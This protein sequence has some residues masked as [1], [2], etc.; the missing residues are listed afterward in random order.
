MGKPIIGS[1]Y[2]DTL[3]KNAQKNTDKKVKQQQQKKQNTGK[4]TQKRNTN[5]S[6]VVNRNNRSSGTTRGRSGATTPGPVKRNGS[7]RQNKTKK[8]QQKQLAAN[9]AAAAKKKN[10]NNS[11]SSAAPAPLANKS[12]YQNSNKTKGNQPQINQRAHEGIISKTGAVLPKS[13][14]QPSTKKNRSSGGFSSKTGTENI[15]KQAGIQVQNKRDALKQAY[16]T[17]DGKVR[18][19]LGV[20]GAWGDT[21]NSKSDK[22]ML[23]AI[24]IA[25][26]NELNSSIRK[27]MKQQY[28]D[29]YNWDTYEPVT[30]D[31]HTGDYT[32]NYTGTAS[33]NADGTWTYSGGKKLSQI[34]Q[35]GASNPRK[36]Q[37]DKDIAKGLTGKA[38]MGAEEVSKAANQ[39]AWL[40]Q[41]DYGTV[42]KAAEG[43]DKYN[44]T[45]QLKQA[46]EKQ[47]GKNWDEE[48]KLGK[49]L[50]GAKAAASEGLYKVNQGIMQTVDFFAP[51]E[52]LFGED[53]A[54]D[55]WL[56][57]WYGDDSKY[58]QQFQNQYDLAYN[59]SGDAG[60]L[61]MWTTSLLTEN[62]PQAIAAIATAGASAVPSLAADGGNMLLNSLQ[63]VI[64]N[65]SFWTSFAQIAGS[66]YNDAKNSGAGDLTATAHAFTTAF[67]Q[68][69]IEID[70]GLETLNRQETAETLGQLFR[71]TVK[72][73][74]EEGG[75]EVQQD[76]IDHLL[77]MGFYDPNKTLFSTTDDDA[78]INPV[79]AAEN[80]AGGA[81]VGGI[82]GG[83]SQALAYGANARYRNA[84]A[85]AQTNTNVQ[86][87][88]ASAGAAPES[89]AVR[90]AETQQEQTG[91]VQHAQS[92]EQH[93]E[94][95]EVSKRIQDTK[96][97]ADE[98]A[99]SQTAQA[100]GKVIEAA[101]AQMS[102]EKEAVLRSLGN[103]GTEDFVQNDMQQAE[104]S[105]QAA[106]A[107]AYASGMQSSGTAQAK[108]AAVSTAA[109]SIGETRAA[110]AFDAGVQDRAQ[111]EQQ[112]TAAAM[113]QSFD[114]A[115][116]EA[117][118]EYQNTESAQND[119]E[120]YFEAFTRYYNAGLTNTLDRVKSSSW[121]KMISQQ[122]ASAAY[123]AGMQDAS[124]RV[125]IQRDIA[126]G[127]AVS[128]KI[129]T[130]VYESDS[131][132]ISGE[133]QNRLSYYASKL[134][135]RIVVKDSVEGGTK[136]GAI[137][138]DTIYLA[139]DAEGDTLEQALTLTASHEITHRMQT[140]APEKYRTFRDY[141]LRQKAEG[142]ADGM[143]QLISE[144]I[145]QYAQ[146]GI[147]LTRQEAMDEIA[148][149]YAANELMTDPESIQA[150]VNSKPKAARSFWQ[151]LRN[152]FK[153]LRR[154][155]DG[156]SAAE[157]KILR[158]MSTAERLWAD[159]FQAASERANGVQQTSSQ[160]VKTKARK[161]E[162]TK[163]LTEK[164]RKNTRYAVKKELSHAEQQFNI[165]QSSNPMHDDVHT[166]IRSANE[167]M[168]FQEVIDDWG[169]GDDITPD[170]T[171]PMVEDA[172]ESGK[173]TVYSSYP[174]EQGVFV[175][176]SLR[177][178]RDYA[179]SGH[180]YE[181]TVLL[182]DVAWIDATEGQ[183]ASVEKNGT[184]YSVKKKTADGGSRMTEDEIKTV[185]SL[186]RK[187]LN[188]LTEAELNKLAPIAER[189]Y[190]TMGEKSP[191]FRAWFG[192]WRVNDQT[193]VQVATKEG[194]A[195]GLQHNADTG[196]DISISRMVFN[197]TTAH[198]GK[199]N[200]SAVSYLDYINDIIKNA[201]LLDTYTIGKTKS[202]NS[203]LMHNFYALANIHGSPEILKLYVEEMYN[204]SGTAT[205]KRAYQLQNIESQQLEVTGST[206]NRLAVSS[207]AD[208]HTVADLFQAVK[209]RD[210]KFSPKAASQIVNEDGSP[211]I[212]YH[213]TDADF[214]VFRT[215]STGAGRGDTILPDG[216][217]F[218][219]SDTDIGVSGQKQMRVYLNVRNPL[220]LKDRASAQAYWEK[221]VAGYKELM[222]ESQRTD[223][224]YNMRMEQ[225]EAEEDAQH[226]KLWQQW[227]NGEISE[228]QYQSGIEEDA[229]EKILQEWKQEEQRITQQAK[230]LLNDYM[231]NSKYDGIILAQDEGSFG[232]S[233]DSVI[234][235]SPNQV[236]SATD[237]VGTFD[238]KNADIRYSAKPRSAESYESEIERLKKQRDEAKRQIKLSEYQQVSP[239][240][241]KRM[242][243]DLLA[244]YRSTANTE[245]LTDTLQTLYGILHKR[246][247]LIDT[248]GA[249]N[250]AESAAE[251]ILD[252]ATVMETEMSETYADLLSDLKRNAISVPRENRGDF[253]DGWSDFKKQ[254]RKYIQLT[255][256]GTPIDEKYVEL[257]EQY[258]EL[259]PAEVVNP[260]DQA[261]LLA[262]TA[263]TFAPVER[264]LTDEEYSA[265]TDAIAQGIID[266]FKETVSLEP[267]YADR[268]K[269]RFDELNEGTK[270]RIAQLKQQQKRALDKLRADM[271]RS[272]ENYRQGSLQIQKEKYEQKISDIQQQIADLKGK[273]RE[274]LK[275]QRMADNMYYGRKSAEQK[276]LVKEKLT[277]VRQQGKANVQT[278][279]LADQM[280]YGKKLAEQKR[281]A[282]EKLQA[283]KQSASE[284]LADEQQRGRERVSE[285]RLADQMHYGR[286]VAETKRN[287][288]EKIKAERKAGT[289]KARNAVA[290]SDARRAAAAENRELKKMN[291]PSLQELGIERHEHLAETE[292]RV[293]EYGAIEPGENPVRNVTLPQSTD[294]HTRVRRFYRTTAEAGQT[295]ERMVTELEKD[296]LHNAAASYTVQS[297]SKSIER[298]KARLASGMD[299][300][301]QWEAIANSDRMPSAPDVALGELMLD[302]A[303][304]SGDTEAALKIT[305]Q[306]AYV[307]TRAG[308]VVQAMRI[309]KRLSGVSQIQYVTRAKNQLQADLNA[310]FGT[311]APN[312]EI[313]QDL[314]ARLMKATTEAEKESVMEEIYQNLAEQLPVTWVD[315]WNA[316]RYFSMLANPRTHIRNVLGNAVFVPAV[317]VKN[318]TA[319]MIEAGAS[320]VYHARTGNVMERTKT[321]RASVPNAARKAAR[322]TAA[323]EYKTQKDIVQGGGKYNP[324]DQIRDKQRIFKSRLMNTLMKGND[325]ALEGEDGLFLR[326]HYVNA[327][328]NY[329]LANNLTEQDLY[330]ANG[331]ET[332]YLAHARSIALQEAQRNTYRDA[333]GL[334][335]ALN[336][337]SRQNKAA[338][339]LVEGLFPFKKTPVNILKRGI[340]YSPA[341]LITAS[342]RAAKDLR[343]GRINVSQYIDRLSAGLTGGGIALLGIALASR[344]MLRAGS[345]GDD[346]K[347][348]YE[349][350][351]LGYQDF[352]LQIGNHS[353][354][355]DWMA[356]AVM[357][358]M[359]GVEVYNALTKEG[360]STSD[361]LDSFA[362][363]A[364]P[365]LSLSMLDGLQSTLQ[366]IA[367]EDGNQLANFS[368]SAISSYVTQGIPTL[369][370]QIARIQQGGSKT[371]YTDPDSWM[372]TYL[373][374][375]IYKAR[376]K[377]P[378]IP[379]A[380][381]GDNKWLQ[382]Y[383][384]HCTIAA[385]Q[386]WVNTWGVVDQSKNVLYNILANMVSPGYY[387]K[388]QVGDTD[389]EILRLYKEFGD[390]SVLPSLPQ[391]RLTIRDADGISQTV[392]LNADQYTQIKKD[393]GSMAYDLLGKLVND[394]NYK[395][396]SDEDKLEMIDKV[397]EY[398]LAICKNNT[399]SRHA[400]TS[401][402]QKIKDS[403][404]NPA[405]AIAAKNRID[406]F[407][408]DDS[409][410]QKEIRQ[411][412]REYISSLSGFSPAQ[413]KALDKIAVSAGTFIPDDT[414]IDYSN[415]E[416]FQI[417]GMS[418]SAQEKWKQAKQNGWDAKRYKELYTIVHS[419][420]GGKKEEKLATAKKSGFT[421]SEFNYI[422]KLA[423]NRKK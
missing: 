116:R 58:A 369:F 367:S 114:S 393:Y 359:V 382:W 101:Q 238:R 119:P 311:K 24:N 307:G 214:S 200:T 23:H 176:P 179:G 318:V 193:S 240:G 303:L 178:A 410:T 299:G 252:D 225:A 276:R 294:G 372:P 175:S 159:A 121:A 403:G 140:Y 41:Q 77:Q 195:R 322:K 79:R 277:Q 141:A 190:R 262:E 82:M 257:N 278:Q 144:T 188:R 20:S 291:A 389:K 186:E 332:K 423:Y 66:S 149:D 181:R 164:S 418:D 4:S 35:Q 21:S 390:T 315:K 396:V 400:L 73:A 404:I 267:T 12:R 241:I 83:G 97:A 228:E 63:R 145:D 387:S 163:S 157:K 251:L 249:Y 285:Q 87:D 56:D 362:L 25:N 47:T 305:E 321:L 304:K 264:S 90:Q 270:Q 310:R 147:P 54:F 108:A 226:A 106:Y 14:L 8:Q 205:L 84:M 7:Q 174:I 394:E 246:P 128:A 223:A 231:H 309:L 288:N 111:V 166:G 199:Y 354:T 162:T 268:Q 383:N 386:D 306:L 421:E 292:Q 289:Q 49:T 94:T 143:E 317:H 37:S 279:S 237:N 355:I 185:Q 296:V 254:N 287:A 215:E 59:T 173:I 337:L 52:L 165:I 379:Q 168:T 5:P 31:S 344:E 9:D 314:Q 198:K 336:K 152:A 273:N 281:N 328:A 210:K 399:D 320:R 115:G 376:N 248:D 220:R 381:V 148:A 271:L 53:N 422:W 327:M 259:F 348:K 351:A 43:Q 275:K 3:R 416:T 139:K 32:L 384:D 170:F 308:Q 92:T 283:H 167:I 221:H 177:I 325:A 189:Y 329:L 30:Y 414:D 39:N 406:A 112:S 342:V 2:N 368:T 158:R 48:T 16:K 253:A 286:Q 230:Q 109:E 397:Y 409:L 194:S 229:S 10:K 102:G 415:A 216:A 62:L 55:K 217:F 347:D 361:I 206:N 340:E 123:E 265:A 28:G 50:Y 417:S 192:D 153:Q 75:E 334:A 375:I 150:F 42:Q 204:P 224:L 6:P 64:K 69:M 171:W 74:W 405:R 71:Q 360:Y 312:L 319:A 218:K 233:T 68:S 274:D 85:D 269:I 184:K 411:K 316:W 105:E 371:V 212:M 78:L 258:P 156:T 183:Y 349:E 133:V 391:K 88:T 207:T 160:R 333:S 243:Q 89:G 227:R 93:S 99:K 326:Y 44:H 244:E 27:S 250:F 211:K 22:D 72:T 127:A 346:D 95:D 358:L 104:A 46:Y 201:V 392:I 15:I 235:F 364:E 13:A 98:A 256:S 120:A 255:N 419:S 81:V 202:P 341:G 377:V 132:D 100:G 356:P 103:A 96:K 266:R 118:K 282:E 70:S 136:N 154:K 67:L 232:R 169:Y 1:V 398:A 300:M 213:Q 51:T 420:K 138:G 290:Q 245:E 80:F 161:P 413:K 91:T 378:A 324:A 408:D 36:H 17:D 402:Q 191:F 197:E 302:R 117:Y 395:S 353:Y 365:M 34:G 65:P 18:A 29:I 135:T 125:Q 313:P 122:A 380:I 298:A 129:G 172:L 345:S 297:N 187:S 137:V 126:D 236:K 45:Q 261:E 209:Q 385:G 363:V 331:V 203:L 86:E 301:Q 131:S 366:S 155:I 388:I 330:D 146:S 242:A 60:K 352:S 76:M 151:K 134:N 338:E 40:S 407:E 284:R 323:A 11:R 247:E 33:Q 280:H 412:Q 222:Q 350:Y 19:M 208:I 196:W 357:P 57:D 130:V 107:A 260:A 263:R 219:S 339:L 180:I 343:A 272:G 113:E 335:T 295:S 61:G 110:A 182:A 124:Q 234:A 26:M 38:K 239:A 370:G 293:G 142:N 373:Q 401:T 374:K